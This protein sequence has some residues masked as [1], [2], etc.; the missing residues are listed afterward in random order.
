[1]G[2]IAS[3]F[4]T[5]INGGG[6]ALL[7]D[8]FNRRLAR[9]DQNPVAQDRKH[10]RRTGTIHILPDE[11]P[12][13][14][15]FAGLD[16]A[17]DFTLPNTHRAILGLIAR[18]L[19]LVHAGT[20]PGADAMSG[21]S[22]RGGEVIKFITECVIPLGNRGLERTAESLGRAAVRRL[23]HLHADAM[24]LHRALGKLEMAG[25]NTAVEELKTLLHVWRKT[26]NKVVRAKR[27]LG[28]SLLLMGVGLGVLAYVLW[29]L[30]ALAG[31]TPTF[32]V[33]GYR[34]Q[35][36]WVGPGILLLGAFLGFL[37]MLRRTW[38]VPV[39]EGRGPLTRAELAYLNT[40]VVRQSL[41]RR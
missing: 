16:A 4:P 3:C 26:G 14:A 31:K 30:G 41:R 27:Y 22:G 20:G 5:E 38:E 23:Y 36:L 35:A 8:L 33:G 1:M 28:L 2:R 15:L 34:V 6:E 25:G 18:R 21:E 10:R 39:T 11:I 24:T 37:T 17:R 9:D 40:A 19:Q 12:A 7:D 29:G 13:P 32:I